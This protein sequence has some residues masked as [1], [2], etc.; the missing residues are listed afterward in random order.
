MFTINLPPVADDSPSTASALRRRTVHGSDVLLLQSIG[1]VGGAGAF[2]PQVLE[3]TKALMT[4][5]WWEAWRL[6]ALMAGVGL[7]GRHR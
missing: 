7:V 2:G 3:K 5:G 4:R 1:G 6:G